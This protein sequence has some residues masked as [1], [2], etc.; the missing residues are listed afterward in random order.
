MRTEQTDVVISV[1]GMWRHKIADRVRSVQRSDRGDAPPEV[2]VT[3][4][5]AAAL[6]AAVVW[7]FYG[8]FGALRWMAIPVGVIAVVSIAVYL[9]IKAQDGIAAKRRRA[10]E[11]GE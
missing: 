5:I 7:L 1:L 9:L 11:T 6:A 4:S 2:L 10:H 3:I 8:R